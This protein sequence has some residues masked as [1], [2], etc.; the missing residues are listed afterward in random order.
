MSSKRFGNFQL[1]QPSTSY[2]KARLDI[3]TISSQQYNQ[4]KQQETA[5][6]KL[7]TPTAIAK[8]SSTDVLWGDEDDEFIVLASQAVEEVELFHQ[9]QS[10]DVTFGRFEKAALP[11]STQAATKKQD[12]CELMPPPV[13][14]PGPSREN[15]APIAVINLLEDD[16]DDVFSE[17]F[18]ENYDNIEKHIDEFFNNEFDEVFNLAGL[19]SSGSGEKIGADQQNGLKTSPVKKTSQEAANEEIKTTTVFKPKQPISRDVGTRKVFNGRLQTQQP[20]TQ[21]D[22]EIK[23]EDHGKDLQIRFL[24]N[25]LEMASKKTEKLQT[26]YNDVLERI[27][28]RDGEVSMLRY[29]LKNIK[30]QNEQLR[31]EKMKESET[32]KQELVAKMKSLEKV[33]LVQKTELDFKNVEMMSMRSKRKSHPFRL[34]DKTATSG[35]SVTVADFIIH[36]RRQRIFDG[37]VAEANITIDPKMFDISAESTTVNNAISEFSRG[38]AILSKHLGQMQAFLSVMVSGNGP[39]QDDTILSATSIANQALLEIYRYCE[40]LQLVQVKEIHMGAKVAFDFL[41]KNSKKFRLEGKANICQREPLSLNEKAI[42]PRRFLAALALLCQFVPSLAV[43]LVQRVGQQE[44]CINVL[45]KSLNKISYATELYDHLGMIAASSALL[46]SLSHHL[47]CLQERGSRVIDL[48]KS[49]VYCRPDSALIVTH[50][51]EA[52]YRI[53]SCEQSIDLVSYICWRSKP[54]CFSWN[55]SFRMFQFTKDSCVLQIYATLLEISVPQN[56]TLDTTEIHRM[57][58]STRNTV[59]FLRNSLARQVRWVNHFRKPLFN[60]ESR[61]A[62]LFCQCHVR[63]TNSFVVL[64]HQLLR[65]WLE[66]PLS[67]EFNTMVQI[68]QHGTTL[69]VDLF[70]IAYRND[71]LLIGGYPI[72][73]RLQATYD[74]LVQHQKDFRFQAVHKKALR[75]LDLRLLMDDPLKSSDDESKMDVDSDSAGTDQA[76]RS[77]YD[78]LCADFFTSKIVQP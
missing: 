30:S 7:K 77:M 53:S 3:E 70:R 19:Q 48:F 74:W 57:V 72:Q 45:S 5:Q 44:S 4:R 43:R 51:S 35:A 58:E 62:P 40:R 76:R 42:I 49:I 1:K 21:T 46:C 8:S 17:Q 59:Y 61:S 15:Q 64:F 22:R 54:E 71:I 25:Q 12:S 69:L 65:C 9:S 14:I 67:I 78:D 31:L 55:R 23:Q 39:L 33:I 36:N 38:D 50:L 2:K 11:C 52:L 6:V 47:E 41:S 29:E 37:S 10:G 66:H 26:D 63:I 34:M 28:I 32:I 16:D 60:R 20:L 18:D 75:L 73:S 68:T 13:A 56:R 24:T 27:Q